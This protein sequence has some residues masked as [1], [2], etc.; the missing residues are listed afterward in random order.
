MIWLTRPIFA[1]TTVD[2][3][4]FCHGTLLT[5]ITN[6]VDDGPLFHLRRYTNAQ[7]YLLQTCLHNTSTTT[8]NRPSGVWAL[9]C[10]YV[11]ITDSSV[12][13]CFKYRSQRL[14][15]GY[16]TC[17]QCAIGDF[18]RVSVAR[19]IGVS[20]YTWFLFVPPFYTLPNCHCSAF[21]ASA[22]ILSHI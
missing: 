20:R 7:V 5:A 15:P 21:F 2:L 22:E 19:S 6:I 10:M 1:S 17:M 9:L 14:L 4:R 3:E 12:A 11:L 16:F 18:A 8:T 13:V